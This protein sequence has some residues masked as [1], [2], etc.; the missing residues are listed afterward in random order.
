MNSLRKIALVVGHNA[1]S[2][3]AVRVTDKMTEFAWNGTLAK[4]L[5][6]IMPS[7]Y[8]ILYRD[9]AGGYAKEIDRVYAEANRINAAATIEL[10]FNGAADPRATGTEVLSSGTR[11][12][13]ILCNG[14]QNAMLQSLKL[15]SR[16]VKVLNKDMRGGRSLW[17]GRAPAALIEPYFGSNPS[18][19][20][21][22]DKN[23]QAF[24]K[25]LH[26]ACSAFLNRPDMA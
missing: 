11:N 19:C 17:A 20:A 3:G 12:S 23:Y 25:S 15:R 10:H 9:P 14:L 18:D 16:G 13:M 6:A 1:K 22:S 5:Q 21:I 24:V 7:R 2:Q 4:D 26:E 8:I